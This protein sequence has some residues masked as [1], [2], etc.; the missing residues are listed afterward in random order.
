MTKQSY[1]YSSFDVVLYLPFHVHIRFENVLKQV[2]FYVHDIKIMVEEIGIPTRK[3]MKILCF[4]Q[5]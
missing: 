2:L 4:T 3:L 1:I 5:L